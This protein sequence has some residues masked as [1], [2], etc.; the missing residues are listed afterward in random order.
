L[1]F[2]ELNKGIDSLYVSFRGTLKEN[3]KEQLEEKKFQA[4]STDEKEQAMAKMIIEDHCFEVKDKGKGLYAYVIVDAW[5]HIQISP[6]Q[7]KTLP[8]VYIQ[9]SS[10]VLSRIGIND[11]MTD[12]RNVIKTLLVTL[13]IETVS[14]ADLFVDFIT[15]VNLETIREIEWIRRAKKLHRY[16][17]ETTF[18]GWSIGLG[19]GIS[20]R[21]YNKTKEIEISHKEYL[22]SIWQ[23]KGWSEGQTVWRLEFE[24]KRDFLKQMSVNTLSDLINI[25]NDLWRYCTNDWLRLVIEGDSENRNRWDTHPLWNMLQQVKHQPGDYTGI[26]RSISKGRIPNERKLFL[27][28]LG[29]LTAYAA[30]KGFDSIDEFTVLGFLSDMRI[31]LKSYIKDMDIY[32]DYTDYLETKINLKKRKYNIA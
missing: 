25:C 5:Y 23:L 21:L 28:G 29:Y 19:G 8:P 31:Y 22:K 18:T 26:M 17:M 13:D 30:M 6:S 27:T 3:I 20:A 4:Q 11:T 9:I 1:T 24:L 2:I 16:W 7:S 32:E 10:D 12:L 15:D 14:R